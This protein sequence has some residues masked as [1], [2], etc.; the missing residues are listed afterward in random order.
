MLRISETTQILNQWTRTSGE[1]GGGGWGGARPVGVRG[2]EVYVG[3]MGGW[4]WGARRRGADVGIG[5]RRRER[6]TDGGNG[7][8]Q[9]GV[10]GW[11]RDGE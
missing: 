1:W 2:K 11:K 4:K 9:C 10:G 5:G 6:E 3:E 8:G 7:C